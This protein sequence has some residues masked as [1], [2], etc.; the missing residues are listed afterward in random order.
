M[1]MPECLSII[2]E[3]CTLSPAK[4]LTW[5]KLD[6]LTKCNQSEQDTELD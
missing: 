2:M 3:F 6:I 1:Q 5:S 4:A